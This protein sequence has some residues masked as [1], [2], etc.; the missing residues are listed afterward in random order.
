MPSRQV[1]FNKTLSSHRETARQLRMSFYA[2]ELTVQ[3]NKHSRC[4]TRLQSTV[5]STV[6]AKNS[7]DMRGRWG[8]LTLYP[9]IF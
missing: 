1:A 7:S 8:F 5:V 9:H 2:G 6:S 4:T 3:F